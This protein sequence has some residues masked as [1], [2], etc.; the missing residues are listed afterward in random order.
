MRNDASALFPAEQFC[1]LACFQ[2]QVHLQSVDFLSFDHRKM[3]R[4]KKIVFKNNILF[5]LKFVIPRMKNMNE[6]LV[7]HRHIMKNYL[8]SYKTKTYLT[9][10]YLVKHPIVQTV[11]ILE[12][13]YICTPFSLIVKAHINI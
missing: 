6:S 1:F 8:Q 9:L 13:S 2:N 11:T 7:P 3:R 4:H 12:T 10:F 5:Q